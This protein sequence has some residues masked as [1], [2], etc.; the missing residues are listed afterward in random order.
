MTTTVV[1]QAPFFVPRPGYDEP[2]DARPTAPYLMNLLSP[3]KF[4]AAVGQVPAKSFAPLLT[5]D[6]PPFWQGAPV[7][8]YITNALISQKMFGAPGQPLQKNWQGQVGQQDDAAPWVG[9]PMR[10]SALWQLV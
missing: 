4:F 6:D 9:S 5:N 7:K 1:P 8:S 3:Q 2:W 10:A